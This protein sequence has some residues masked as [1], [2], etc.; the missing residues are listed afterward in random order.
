MQGSE[1]ATPRA[2]YRRRREE[3]GGTAARQGRLARAIADARL[4]V[5]LA[6]LVVAWLALAQGRS[7]PGG[8]RRRS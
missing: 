1:G 5:F 4:A 2:E 8:W 7:R 6:G 3:R